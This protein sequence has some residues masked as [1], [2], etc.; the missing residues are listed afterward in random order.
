MEHESDEDLRAKSL[1]HYLCVKGCGK[2]SSL[3][4]SVFSPQFF[5]PYAPQLLQG[6]FSCAIHVMF[7]LA[8]RDC[9]EIE[10]AQFPVSC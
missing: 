1:C 10:T 5:T 6:S 4:S 8:A 7:E 3:L 9:T 2:L